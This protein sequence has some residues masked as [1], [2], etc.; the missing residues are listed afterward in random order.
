MSSY[1]RAKRN[2]HAS[3]TASERVRTKNRKKSPN[4]WTYEKNAEKV[5]QNL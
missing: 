3:I 2:F 4:V 5:R 1:I